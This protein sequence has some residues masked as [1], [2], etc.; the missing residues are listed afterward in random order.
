MARRR[1]VILPYSKLNKEVGLVLVKNG[2]LEEIKEEA[3]DGK[4]ILKAV[5]RYEKRIPVM[6]GV[7]LISKPSL[8]AF[9]RSKNIYDLEKKGKRVLIIS[10]SQGVMTGKEARKKGIGGEALF[11]IW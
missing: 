10:T 6:M 8:K 3:T 11:A 9:E 7:T 1:K 5:V 4:K 2:F